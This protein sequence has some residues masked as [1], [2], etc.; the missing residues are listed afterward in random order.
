MSRAAKLWK[1]AWLL[2]LFALLAFGLW[3]VRLDVD[4]FNLLPDSLPVVHGLK[5]YQKHF[6][7]TR[8]LIVTVRA[9]NAEN[10]ESAARQLAEKLRAQTNLISG[11]VWQ[12]P[13]LEHPEEMVELIA[14]L[15]LNQP[16]EAFAQLTNRLA[17]EKLAALLRESREQLAT[18]L[19]PTD[20]GRLSYDP[21][22]FTRLPNSGLED[23]NIFSGSQE[24]F[25]SADGAFRVVYVEAHD[26]LQDYRACAAWLAEIQATAGRCQQATNW[27]GPVTVRFTG[28]PA[29]TT[30][31]ATGMERDLKG[32]VL[33]TLT[34]IL[35]LFW[36][37]HR[38]WRPLFWLMTMLALVIAGTLAS[39]GLIFGKLNA[40][41]LGFAAVLLGLAVD[42]GLVLYQESLSA[43]RL[44]ARELRGLLAPSIVWSAVTTA[45][46]FGLLNF[47]GLPGLSQLGSLVGIGILLAALVMLFVFLPLILRRKPATI[48][49][50]EIHAET[51]RTSPPS[52]GWLARAVTVTVFVATVGILWRAWPRVNHSNSPLQPKH[53]AAQVSLDELQAELSRQGDPLL[54][55]VSGRNELEVA[56][57]LEASEAH[58]ARAVTNGWLRSYLLPTALWPHAER[59]RL[60]L[61]MAGTLAA[62]ADAMKAAA[63]AAGFTDDA[64]AL[65]TKLLR[66]WTAQAG[67]TNVLWPTNQSSRWLLKRAVA[68]TG[69]DWLAVGA[70]YPAT[71]TPPAA[72]L[73]QLNPALPGVSLTGWTQLGETLLQSVEH[74]L[75]G[76]LA[77]SVAIVGLCL[78]MAFR[79]WREVLLSF[80]TLAFSLL[81]LFAVMGL[82]GWTWNLMNLMAVPLLLGAGVDYTIH[83]QL[84][85]RRHGGDAVTMRRITGRAVFLCAATTV[86]GFGS[87][88]LSGNAGLASLGMICA[89]GI[90]ITYLASVFLLPAWWVVLNPK[91]ENGSALSPATA[92][93]PSAVRPSPSSFYRAG[94]WQA[95]LV[96]VRVLPVW[97]VNGFCRVIAEFHFRL[98][99][100]RREVVVC[101][102]LPPCSDDRAAAERMA[103]RLYRRFAVKLADL[104][105][106]EAGVSVRNWVTDP[107]QALL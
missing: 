81:A 52:S 35:V 64:L 30:E 50:P 58:L 10:A 94:L 32:S 97:V 54:L 56:R 61:V 19:S 102:L 107:R 2:P 69:Q 93:P 55:V 92:A 82:A 68:W 88:A 25:A 7:S 6:A 86:A 26:S 103:R 57:R 49:A 84:A 29:F 9:G 45:A 70:L 17:P 71:N 18:S 59:Q 47:G 66:T 105:R 99:R 79:R 14:H 13:W 43:P 44:S 11:V 15:W 28:A 77:A 12:P 72:R 104:W 34:L 74:R 91:S 5:L 76:V 38:S 3:R 80:A 31:V 65:M 75:W 100:E 46:A 4:I 78:W 21:L 73:A 89:A 106:V 33:A 53:S 95:G 42:Y 27:P 62:R 60:N 51:A 20:I 41:S 39:G 37:A 22:G 96:I 101:N 16:P 24:G 67:T 85:L 8:E 87:N 40:V 1:P 48:P 63:T 98:Q 23:G 90:A 83:V 36:W